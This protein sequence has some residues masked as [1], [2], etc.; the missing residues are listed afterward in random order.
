MASVHP[1]RDPRA[2]VGTTRRVVPGP[3]VPRG[4]NGPAVLAMGILGVMLM[5]FPVFAMIAWA[6]GASEVRAINRGEARSDGRSLVT[7]GY[8]F[9]IFGT[10]VGVLICLSCCVVFGR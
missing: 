7:I 6:M 1:S 9:G 3:T 2:H 5:P 10:C 8:F 4:N